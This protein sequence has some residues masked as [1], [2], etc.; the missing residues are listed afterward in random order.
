MGIDMVAVTLDSPGLSAIGVTVRAVIV[1]TDEVEEPLT[2]VSG[3]VGFA[4]DKLVRVTV[5]S[6]LVCIIQA[7]KIFIV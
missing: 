7:S 3:S 4:G 6:M 5:A 1:P 2:N